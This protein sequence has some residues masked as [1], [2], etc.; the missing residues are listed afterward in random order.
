MKWFLLFVFCI[1]LAFVPWRKVFTYAKPY[2]GRVFIG[3]ALAALV[4][5]LTFNFGAIKLL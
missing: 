5:V 2:A 1:G 3:A 4:V